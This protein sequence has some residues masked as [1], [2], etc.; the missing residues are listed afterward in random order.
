[1]VRQIQLFNNDNSQQQNIG[2]GA[3]SDAFAS[4]HTIE[5]TQANKWEIANRHTIRSPEIMQAV[6]NLD[7][8]ADEA[9]K[10]QLAGWIDE[11][12]K[13]RGGG[14][15]LA[16]FSKCYLGEPYVDHQITLSGYIVEHYQRDQ[17]VPPIFSKA[18]PLAQSNAYEFIEIY[19]DGEV[20]PIRA[21]GSEG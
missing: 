11:A 12:Y 20:I 5:S 14:N 7:M 21:D 8:T 13:A 19:A 9:Y 15:L 3:I 6:R 18:R 16:L 2:A 1:M 10:Q 4:S 17:Q